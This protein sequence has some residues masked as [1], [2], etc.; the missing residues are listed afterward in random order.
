LN[1]ADINHLNS[2]IKHKEIEAAIKSLPKTKSPG[3]DRFTPEFY[4]IFKEELISILLKIFH[5]VKWEGTL[6]NSLY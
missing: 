1:Q 6:P 2:S 3:P 4:Q 5:D